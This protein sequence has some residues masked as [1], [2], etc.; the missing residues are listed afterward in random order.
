MGVQPNT[1]LARRSSLRDGSTI[2][3]ERPHRRSF[4]I[5]S[6]G[7]AGTG[8]TN[9]GKNL[10]DTPT[11]RGRNHTRS[12]S[13]Q[14][15]GQGA[16]GGEE[17]STIDDVNT[18]MGTPDLRA[19]E[20]QLISS[21]A[22]R[23]NNITGEDIKKLKQADPSTPELQDSA[24]PESQ[25]LSSLASPGSPRT[26]Q[27]FKLPTKPL[28]KNNK[29]RLSRYSVGSEAT[30][31]ATG[32]SIEQHTH[33]EHDR[34]RESLIS[35]RRR[36]SQI[37]NDQPAHL[38]IGYAQITGSFTL[39]G[40]LVDQTPFEEVKRK[41][42]MNSQAGGGVV[43][44]EKQ[45]P[46]GGLF[47]LGWGSIGDSLTGL[48]GM[49]DKS[50]IRQMRSAVNTKSI[51]LLHTPQSILFVDLNLSPGETRSY[52]YRS[53]LPK[54]LP[55]SYKGRAIKINYN[56]QITLQKSSSSEKQDISHVEV[57]F[58]TQ[59]SVD[60]KCPQHSIRFRILTL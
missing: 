16:K 60:R 39:D 59:G 46:E 40:S 33:V 38:M 9:D 50:S 41:G 51:P 25:D 11:K 4:S 30:V 42:I 48:L 32:D 17:L 1:P 28:P 58:R 12:I 53:K 31:S 15:F 20:K 7:S 29:R 14:T 55:P 45:K 47:G 23:N 34:R 52:T 36:S 27:G 35:N 43:G 22:R 6:A 13:I 19:D 37:T 21:Q 56:L 44:I 18:P 26:L 2:G 54:G 8:T 57:P 49:D 10:P 24:D 3:Q 5:R